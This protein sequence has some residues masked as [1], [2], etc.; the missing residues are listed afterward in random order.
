MNKNIIIGAGF[1]AGI[2]KILTRKNT[3]VI[4][5]KSH[6]FSKDFFEENL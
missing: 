2:T 6:L 3:R 4:G 5:S 1:S